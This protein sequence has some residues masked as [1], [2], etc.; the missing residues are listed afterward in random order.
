MRLAKKKQK[1]NKEEYIQ[2]R[3]EAATATSFGRRC[4][5]V[6]GEADD[7]LSADALLYPLLGGIAIML[8][9]SGAVF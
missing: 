8:D 5:A 4:L 6:L 7:K 9:L 1:L 2:N 3:V